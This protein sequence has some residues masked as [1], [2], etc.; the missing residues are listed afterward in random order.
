MKKYCIDIDGTICTNTNGN[1]EKAE[2]FPGRIEQINQLHKEGNTI[3][4]FTA[5]GTSS[6]VDW[7]E[8]T[9]IQLNKW[10]LFYDELLFGKPEAD[11]FIDDKA[12]DVFKW[13]I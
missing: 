9:K 7:E 13:F 1:Y 4:L 3:I 6:G 12:E 2:P 5:R 11:I 8:V 10:G